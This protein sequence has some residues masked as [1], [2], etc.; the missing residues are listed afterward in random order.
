MRSS[1][2]AKIPSAAFCGIASRWTIETCGSFFAAF[3]A[4]REPYRSFWVENLTWT[5]G[6]SALNWSTIFLRNGPSPPVNGFQKSSFT[7]VAGGWIAR[8]PLAPA[9][10]LPDAA[11]AA[12]APVP[13]LA[14]APAPALAP[15]L[16]LLPL[17]AAMRGAR[18]AI[19]APTPASFSRSRLV[20]ERSAIVT[21]DSRG[22]F[23]SS[24]ATLTSSNHGDNDAR[25]AR[26]VAERQHVA[27]R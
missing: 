17:H 27:R 7:A 9:A 18:T 16:A 10:A 12:L 24:F 25:F 22:L 2:G 11:G 5:F 23:R 15:A 4:W 13:A 3:A 14:P 21:A 8:P 20:T 1:I 6:V 19:P 26:A